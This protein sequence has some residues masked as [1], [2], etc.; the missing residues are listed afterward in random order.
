LGDAIVPLTRG[1]FELLCRLIE[2][3]GKIVS[4]EAL[5]EAVSRGEDSDVRSVDALVSRLRRKLVQAASEPLIVTAPG[6]G[7]RL[8]VNADPI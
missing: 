4:R 8:G 1:E 6:F 7:Y 3:H 2:A 5:S